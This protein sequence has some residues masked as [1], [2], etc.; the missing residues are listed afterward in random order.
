MVIWFDAKDKAY[1]VRALGLPEVVTFGTS[2]ADAKIMAKD[3]I[4]LYCD[5]VIKEGNIIIDDQRRVVGKIPQ[6]R[7]IAIAR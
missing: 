7:V 2:L 1:L 6:S 5:G 3:A 4:E